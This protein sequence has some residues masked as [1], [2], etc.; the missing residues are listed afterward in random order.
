MGETFLK[1]PVTNLKTTENKNLII[2]T[3]S[4]S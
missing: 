4:D 3:K 2:N 1:K